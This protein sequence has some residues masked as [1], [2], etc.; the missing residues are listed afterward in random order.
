MAEWL[1]HGMVSEAQVREACERMAALVDGQ[2][3]G[4]SLLHAWRLKV[5]AG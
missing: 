4:D 2:S 5:M 3:A 1:H